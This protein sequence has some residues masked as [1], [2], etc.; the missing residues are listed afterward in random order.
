[1]FVQ[2]HNRSL[3]LL[4]IGMLHC[5]KQWCIQL[6]ITFFNNLTPKGTKE[7]ESSNIDYSNT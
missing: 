3:D 1:M 6:Q 4:K 7:Q 2:R 5:V